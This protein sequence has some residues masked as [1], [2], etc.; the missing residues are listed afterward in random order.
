MKH[1]EILAARR[2]PPYPTARKL[3]Q[4]HSNRKTRKQERKARGK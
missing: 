1:H 4:A 3:R 2:T